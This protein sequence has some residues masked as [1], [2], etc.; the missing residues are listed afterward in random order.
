MRVKFG[1]PYK[2]IAIIVILAVI[3]ESF[4]FSGWGIGSLGRTDAKV[5]EVNDDR[6]IAADISNM[7][8][9]EM[10]RILKIKETGKS[11]N[12]VL[13]LLKAKDDGQNREAKAKRTLNLLET[14]LGEEAITR[15]LS[16]GYA[17]KEILN[18]K[19]MAERIALQIKQLVDEPNSKAPEI[20]S[21][22]QKVSSNNEQEAFLVELRSVAGQFDLEEAVHFMLSLKTE[23][24]SYEAVL[25]EYLLTLQLGLNLEDYIQNKAKYLKDKEQ[26]DIEK[27]GRSV[28]TL[29][30]IERILLDKIRRENESQKETT[31]INPNNPL[32][33]KTE[34]V[35]KNPLPEVP[36]PK[37]KDVKP[38]SPTEAI[39][40]ELKSI[41]PNVPKQ[42]KETKR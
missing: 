17:E 41:D 6:K 22:S 8:G 29:S 33:A 21:A 42:D 3:A 4:M 5:A 37:I 28:I 9:V 7:T 11:W 10:E 31:S 2:V 26:K 36:M 15:F 23:F 38:V 32:Q 13:E 35:T 12:E 27:V 25:D 1:K 14:G 39:K 19:L 16:Q 20:P 34:D 18:A 30:E 24:G 40:E